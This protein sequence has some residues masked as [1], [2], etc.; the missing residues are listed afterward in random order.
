MQLLIYSYETP[1]KVTKSIRFHLTKVSTASDSKTELNYIPTI[2][3]K[4]AMV[5]CLKNCTRMSPHAQPKDI[6]RFSEVSLHSACIL[7][8]P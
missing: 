1:S 5:L 4:K 3:Q 7:I 2:T 6:K 8:L